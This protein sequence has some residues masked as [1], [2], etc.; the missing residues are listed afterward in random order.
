MFV[1]IMLVCFVIYLL[2][3]GDFKVVRIK[4]FIFDVILVGLELKI[5]FW[6]K[7]YV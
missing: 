6:V 3:V 5:S 2:G 4:N 1:Y 7:F